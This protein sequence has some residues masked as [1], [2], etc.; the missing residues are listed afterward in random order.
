[1]T[2]PVEVPVGMQ[3]CFAI[4][5]GNTD[6]VRELLSSVK[7]N[8]LIQELS[9]SG[10]S[11]AL[12]GC[13]ASEQSPEAI[14]AKLKEL[15]P[16]E[17]REYLSAPPS[18]QNIQDA[19]N[20]AVP[21]IKHKLITLL[22]TVMSHT[23]T[24][25]AD[26]PNTK[27]TRDACIATLRRFLNDQELEDDKRSLAEKVLKQ[28][29]EASPTNENTTRPGVLETVLAMERERHYLP[30]RTLEKRLDRHSA[31]LREESSRKKPRS[32]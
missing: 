8:E 5:S 13:W 17:S 19:F 7:N 6:R 20:I 32:V 18:K 28:F 24:E 27:F 31:V 16:H 22:G 9:G 15:Y 21:M 30:S 23:A 1:M 14:S 2:I 29:P 10:V 25:Q 11:P 26:D 12:F 4:A 3:F